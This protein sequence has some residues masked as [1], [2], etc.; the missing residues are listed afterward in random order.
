MRCLMLELIDILMS[1][2]IDCILVLE[3][4]KKAVFVAG[5]TI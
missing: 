3:Y 4:S 5:I 2:D 1:Q